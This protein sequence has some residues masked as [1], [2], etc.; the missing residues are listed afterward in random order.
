MLQA[1]NG[2]GAHRW[3]M[4]GGE[5][6]LPH[7]LGEREGGKRG[8][9]GQVFVVVDL[10][11]PAKTVVCLGP[12]RQLHLMQKKYIFSPPPCP[13]GKRIMEPSWDGIQGNYR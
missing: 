9:C 8:L 2:S 13:Y 6:E 12:C 11:A 7:T 4:E 1:K 5:G 3:Q 10:A